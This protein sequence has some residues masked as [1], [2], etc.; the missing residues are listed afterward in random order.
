MPPSGREVDR[1][2]TGG[3][4]LSRVFKRFHFSLRAFLL[5]FAVVAVF[6]YVW[7]IRPTQV[8]KIFA[9][10]I[11]AEKY[12]AADRLFQHTD[13]RFLSE[14]VKKYWGFRSQASLR[15]MS[16]SQ[17]LL[18]HR[19]VELQY[20]YFHLDQQS[21]CEA[22]ILVM[23]F[24]LKPMGKSRTDSAIIIDRDTAV[25]PQDIR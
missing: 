2:A 13:D 22:K 4:G 14:S 10:A 19:I 5:L 17:L 8:A 1:T 7:F 15:P 25:I 16:I 21:H 23:P 12:A 3:R 11:A 20:S 6:C 24:G 18:G 9:S